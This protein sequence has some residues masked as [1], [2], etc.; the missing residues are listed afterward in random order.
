M[1][2]L[3][4]TLYTLFGNLNYSYPPKSLFWL[5]S[6]FYKEVQQ[7]DH[8][9]ALCNA[10]LH[11]TVSHGFHGFLKPLPSWVTWPLNPYWYLRVILWPKFEL[12]YCTHPSIFFVENRHGCCPNKRKSYHLLSRNLSL[13]LFLHLPQYCEIGK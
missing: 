9:V 4:P 11:F 3:L 13:S 5:F 6:I 7:I 10:I 8:P 1:P 12:L 2:V